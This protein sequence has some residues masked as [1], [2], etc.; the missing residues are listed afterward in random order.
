MPI[1]T[2][3]WAFHLAAWHGKTA[4]KIRQ[5]R[6]KNSFLFILNNIIIIR[7]PYPPDSCPGITD[8]IVQYVSVFE[9][10]HPSRTLLRV[11]TNDWS[12]PGEVPVIFCGISFHVPHSLIHEGHLPGQT[13]LLLRYGNAIHI[14][15]YRQSGHTSNYPGYSKWCQDVLSSMETGKKG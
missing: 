10:F 14:L 7:F 6:I 4:V 12:L 11:Q 9:V 13:V 8:C 2:A 15:F 3:C 5:L 1:I